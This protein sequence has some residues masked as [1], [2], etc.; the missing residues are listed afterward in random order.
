MYLKAMDGEE[1]NETL[2]PRS[3]APPARG[4]TLVSTPSEIKRKKKERKLKCLYSSQ[5]KTIKSFLQQL[6]WKH[7]FF[8]LYVDGKLYNCLQFDVY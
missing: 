3:S 2:Q 5:R 1:E 8:F 6:G 4:G 7:V